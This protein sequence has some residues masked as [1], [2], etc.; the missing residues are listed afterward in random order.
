MDGDQPII[1]NLCYNSIFAFSNSYS[2]KALK[3][4]QLVITDEHRQTAS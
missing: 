2:N 4:E 1:T 3:I